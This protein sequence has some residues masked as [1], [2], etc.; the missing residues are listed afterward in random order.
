MTEDHPR[1]ERGSGILLP[2][3]SL[4]SNFGIGDMGPS[5]YAFLDYLARSRQKYWQILPLNPTETASDNSPYHSSSAFAS[6]PLLISPELMVRANLL[7]A[8]DLKKRP[9]FPES[10]TDYESIYT[11]KNAL[12]DK[13]FLRFQRMKVPGYKEYCRRNAGWLED[14]SL[15]SAISSQFPAQSWNRWPE[16]LRNRVPETLEAAESE[17]RESIMRSHFIQFVFNAQWKDLK[18]YAASHNIRIIGDLPIYVTHHSADVWAHPELFQ[19]DDLGEP[20]FTAGVPP[21]YFSATG[22]LWGN[23]LYDWDVLR[24]QGYGWWIRRLQHASNLFDAIRIDHFRGFV[25]YWRIPTGEKN[26]VDGEWIKAPAQDFFLTVNRELPELNVI[27]EDLGTITPDVRRIIRRFDFPGMKVLLFAFGENSPD[28]PYLPHTYKSNCVVYTGTHD[29]NT[30][31]GWFQKEANRK[32][33]ERVYR[34]IGR[35]VSCEE[36]SWEMVKLAMMSPA[37]LCITPIQDILGLGEDARINHPARNKGNWRWRLSS[38]QL[39]DTAA[40]ELGLLTAAAGRAETASEPFKSSAS[41]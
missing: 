19:L 34:Y 32:D 14:Y 25:G 18:S 39:D 29:N 33:R 12:F 21:D 6:N 17:L 40:R 30:V 31:K 7:T 37:D 15:F 1:F 26:A 13:A 28:H 41:L 38:R 36:I 11:Y 9:Q 2:V 8:E 5:A 4:P 20:A 24:R 10:I 27:A 22:Q 16:G 3:A 23:P 35:K